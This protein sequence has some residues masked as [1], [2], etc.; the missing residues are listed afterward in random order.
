MCSVPY[1]NEA[2]ERCLR[3]YESLGMSFSDK[4]KLIAQMQEL[5]VMKYSQFAHYGMMLHYL[6]NGQ[7]ISMNDFDHM[8]DTSFLA[9]T[10]FPVA[11]DVSEDR[12]VVYENIYHFE[13]LLLNEVA[14]GQSSLYAAELNDMVQKGRLA[15][16]PTEYANV[17]E[18]SRSRKDSLLILNALECHKAIEAG[19]L[20]MNQLHQNIHQTYCAL[21]QEAM[22][23]KTQYSPVIRKCITYLKNNITSGVTTAQLA[24]QAG[25]EPYYLNRVFKTEVGISPKQYYRNLMLLESEISIADAAEYLHYSSYTHF[26][27]DFKA[28]M[29]CTPTDYRKSHK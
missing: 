14:Q 6:V 20:G 7:R 13:N 11:S 1:S 21:V 5:P 3:Q 15:T 26:C 8:Q 12:D 10:P 25:Y 9:T 18:P 4:H 16:V 28:V 24:D 2:M 19:V 27:S 22:D 23:E 29:N 17:V